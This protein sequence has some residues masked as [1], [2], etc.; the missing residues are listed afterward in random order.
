MH[1]SSSRAVLFGSLALVTIGAKLGKIAVSYLKYLPTQRVIIAILVLLVVGIGATVLAWWIAKRVRL[2]L[3]GSSYFVAIVSIFLLLAMILEAVIAMAFGGFKGILGKGLAIFSWD[4][5]LLALFVLASQPLMMVQGKPWRFLCRT[6]VFATCWILMMVALADLGY[7]ITTGTNANWPL[8]Q[9]VLRNPGLALPA[10]AGGLSALQMLLLATPLILVITAIVTS[11]LTDSQRSLSASYS[12]RQY[13]VPLGVALIALL[14]A[15]LIPDRFAT[16][17]SRPFVH[18]PVIEIVR[19]IIRRP[20]WNRDDVVPDPSTLSLTDYPPGTS[21]KAS[22]A[23]RP[24]IVLIIVESGR[25]SAMPPFGDVRGVMPFVERISDRS[26]I[27]ERMYPTTPCTSESLISLFYGVAPPIT[28]RLLY[29]EI[30]RPSWTGMMSGLGY[31]SAFFSA[32]DFVESRGEREMV[33]NVGFE[34]V[35]DGRDLSAGR[36]ASLNYSGA[37]DEVFVSPSL[38]WIDAVRQEGAPFL[39]AYHTNAS[40]HPYVLPTSIDIYSDFAE[41]ES[42]NRYLNAL[43]YTDSVIEKLFG[44]FETRGLIEETVFAIVGDHG[45]LFGE[46]GATFPHC[47][48]LWEDAIRVPFILYAPGSRSKRSVA[49]GPLQL[50][51]VF[52][53]ILDLMGATVSGEA[54]PGLSAARGQRRTTVMLSASANQSMALLRDSLKYLYFFRRQEMKVFNVVSDPKEAVDLAG[55]INDQQRDQIE[56]ELFRWR[57]AVNGSYG[58]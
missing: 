52:P 31:R 13:P 20:V 8:L 44:E 37:A 2:E 25:A 51:D 55:N 17:I 46:H 9:Y 33:G 12:E 30:R 58:L 38:D 45:E 22:R 24:N 11:A 15:L 41:N 5:F 48:F 19:E 56:A 14:C 57:G 32:V 3:D 1:S 4:I 47:H 18:N 34:R 27:V 50:I 49:S 35:M 42:Y 26:L 29:S 21:L 6:I 10:I 40:H 28:A 53:T 39:V 23:A 36:A 54:T 16:D 43:R 7:F